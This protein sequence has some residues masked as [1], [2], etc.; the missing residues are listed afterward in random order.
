MGERGLLQLVRRFN[1]VTLAELEGAGYL[2]FTFHRARIGT[3]DPAVVDQLRTFGDVFTVHPD[4]VQLNDKLT[5]YEQRSEAV[6]TFLEE[7]RERK[8]FPTLAGWRNECYEIRPRFSQ[9]PIFKMERSG[10]PLFGLRQYGV[11]INGFV[12]TSEKEKSIWI[13]RRSKTKPTYPGKLGK[14]LT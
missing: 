2:P 5:T 3:V 1:N 4:R 14:L 8:V 7:M 10:T 9:V 12:Q 6:R 13:Q 11:H